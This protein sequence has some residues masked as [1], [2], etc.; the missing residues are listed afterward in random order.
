MVV[1]QVVAK[2]KKVVQVKEVLKVLKVIEVRQVLK[3]IKVQAVLRVHKV[4][5]HKKLHLVL[6]VKQVLRVQQV[7][8]TPL[9]QS[10]V[11][12]DQKVKKVNRVVSVQ[13]D[14]QVLVAVAVNVFHTVHKLKWR[15]ALT[16][17]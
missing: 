9:R 16:R 3:V 2:V 17:M 6:K 15:M 10:V 4:I 8:I 11:L 12:Q 1:V 14:L 5:G 13:R 7:I